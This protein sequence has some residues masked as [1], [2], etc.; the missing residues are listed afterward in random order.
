MYPDDAHDWALVLAAGDGSRLH[1]LTTPAGGLP[2]PKQFC[3]LDGGASLLQEALHRAES[4]TSAARVC[5]V[6]AAGHRHWWES[7]LR[8]LPRDNVVVQPMNR[9][10]A[11]GILLPLLQL[12]RR[13]PRARVALL[14]SDHYVR[15]ESVLARSLRSALADAAQ[16]SEDV[17][18]LGMRPEGPDPEL[19]YV[20]PGPADGTGIAPVASF[21]EKPG[22]V[23]AGSLIARG[24]VWNSFIIVARL[25]ALLAMFERQF[26][27][28]VSALG[29]ALGREQ[30]GDQAAVR[31]LYAALPSIDFSRHLLQ[32]QER[33]L[34]LVSVPACGWSDL[35]TPRRVAEA[36]QR[37][38]RRAPRAPGMHAPISSLDLAAQHSRLQLAG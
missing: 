1:S 14:P 13:D 34:R 3:S 20:L 2:V 4:I 26:P 17:L 31:D 28:V 5:T 9:G 16:Y 30:R 12:A 27:E 35:G 19:G 15:D 18:L 33:F 7:P 36:L 38:A 10:T 37:G 22:P 23:E 8:L 25:E 29:L 21:I 11:V 6:V 24:A 32:G